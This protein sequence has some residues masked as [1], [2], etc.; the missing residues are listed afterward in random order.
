MIVI[1][2]IQLIGVDLD[3]TGRRLN[4]SSEHDAGMT[5]WVETASTR[6]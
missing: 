5:A 1:L 6:K 2:I 4:G 3:C